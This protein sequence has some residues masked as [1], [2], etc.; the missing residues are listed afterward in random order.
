MKTT[1]KLLGIACALFALTVGASRISAAEMNTTADELAIQKLFVKYVFALDLHD[2]K[3]YAALFTPD[4]VITMGERKI[5]GTSGIESLIQ[6]YK[7][8]IDYSKIKAD[9]HGRKFG[10]V[11]HVNTAFLINVNGD[12]A[13]SESYWMEVRS[14]ADMNGIG[15]RPSVINMGRY[16]DELVKRNGQWLFSHRSIVAD[17]YDSSQGGT[18]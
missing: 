1:S 9:S 15:D 18:Q 5:V 6:G 16:E 17:M 4:A 7:D 12:T 10:P 11:R 2:P 13:T 14:N 8:R 3:A